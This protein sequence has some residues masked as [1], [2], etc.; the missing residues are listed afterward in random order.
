MNKRD[1]EFNNL[2][3]HYGNVS[4]GLGIGLHFAPGLIGSLYG[5]SLDAGGIHKA[6]QLGVELLMLGIIPW[7]AKKDP[8]TSAL[9]VIHIGQLIGD[10]GGAVVALVG[11]FS[12]TVRFLGWVGVIAYLVLASGFGYCL[13]KPQH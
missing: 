2:N 5:L 13:F 7:L 12:A 10:T 6:R 8:R 11:Q 9:R 1:D 4:F 3:R